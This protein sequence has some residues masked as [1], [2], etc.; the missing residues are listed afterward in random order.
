MIANPPEYQFLREFIDMMF[1]ILFILAI[2]RFTLFCVKYVFAPVKLFFEGIMSLL[3]FISDKSQEFIDDYEQ[4]KNPKIVK[5]NKPKIKQ[6]TKDKVP[7]HSSN[8]DNSKV[9]DFTKFKRK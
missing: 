2:L 8:A 4:E 7:V 3:G 5:V 9:I 1:G 6:V